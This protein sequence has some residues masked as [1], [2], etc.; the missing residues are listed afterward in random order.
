MEILFF[1]ESCVF[2]CQSWVRWIKRSFSSGFF[3]KPRGL[4]SGRR[5]QKNWIRINHR[6][7]VWYKRQCGKVKE[8]C[9]VLKWV[10]VVKCSQVL[11]CSLW[12]MIVRADIV[13]RDTIP[14]IFTAPPAAWGSGQMF[15]YFDYITLIFLAA[16][17][18]VSYAVHIKRGGG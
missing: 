10:Y 5:T 16:S 8:W 6:V 7:V 1:A 2:F 4:G 9:S 14:D 17:E 18:D 13:A 15:I 12:L 3:L 11:R